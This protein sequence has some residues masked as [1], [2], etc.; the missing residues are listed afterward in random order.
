MD[1]LL[2]SIEAIDYLCIG[3]LFQIQNLKE[4]EESIDKLWTRTKEVAIKFIMENGDFP[5]T[6]TMPCG[7]LLKLKTADD[8]LKLPIENMPCPCGNPKH[9]FIQYKVF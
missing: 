9:W 7:E 5:A 3:L 6:F 4:A 1:E 2:I 8:I